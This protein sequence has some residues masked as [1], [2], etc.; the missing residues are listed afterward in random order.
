MTPIKKKLLRIMMVTVVA[1]LL[2]ACG[3]FSI[4]EVVSVRQSMLA[5]TS[6]LGEIIA[7]NST[8]ALTFNDP[9]AVSETL[10]S[11]RS[12]RHV[13]QAR[14][15][16]RDGSLFAEYGRD[17]VKPIEGPLHARGEYAQFTRHS[18]TVLRPIRFND[19]VIGSVYVEHDLSELK[20]RLLRYSLI[21]AGVLL[22]AL[23]AAFLLADRLQGAISGPILALAE[24]ARSIRNSGNY[25]MAQITG[26]YMEAGLLI[27]SFNDMINGIAERDAALLHH[28]E[29]LEEEVASRTAELR[30]VNSQLERAR[31]AAEAASRAKSE[32]L[33]N[34]SHEVRTPMNGILGMTELALDTDL[35]PL[36]REY[37]TLVRSSA[38]G[39]LNV[40]NDI[41]DFSKIEAGKLSLDSR[42]FAFYG[43]IAEVMKTLAVRAHQKGLELAFEVQEQIPADLAGDVGRLR[44]VIVNL[45]GNAI[46][47]TERGEVVLSVTQEQA[48]EKSVLLHFAIRDTGLGI[49]KDKLARIFEAFEQ[50]DTSTTR[51]HGG[52][53]L[54]LTISVRLVE[55]MQGKIWVES[56]PGRGSTFHFTARFETCNQQS[57]EQA[58]DVLQLRDKRALVVDDNATNRRIL[59]QML[60]NWGMQV[61]LAESGARV[62]K[63]LEDVGS[64]GNRYSLLL[65]D[66]HMPGMDGFMLLEAIRKAKVVNPA[67][68]I[69]LT[70]GDQPDDIRRSRELNIAEYAIK[71]ISQSELLALVLRAVAPHRASA[72]KKAGQTARKGSGQ[73]RPLRILLA[74]DNRLNQKVALGMLGRMRHVVTV[75]NNGREA[76]HAYQQREYDLVF[77]DIQMPEMDGFCAAEMIRVQQEKDGRKV[78]IIAM[79]AHAMAG[80]R[81]KCLAAGMDD[82]VSKPISYEE[83]RNA[84]LRTVPHP[85]ENHGEAQEGSAPVLNGSESKL[86][87][88]AQQPAQTPQSEF[89]DLEIVLDRC[90]GDQELLLDLAKMFPTEASNSLAALKQAHERGDL[91]GVRLHAH[92]LKGMCRA[93]ELR[94]TAE[95]AAALE[96]TARRQIQ[97]SQAQME[98][99]ESVLYQAIASVEQ[100]RTELEQLPSAVS[101]AQS[102]DAVVLEK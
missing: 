76:V 66:R 83:L 36:T 46:K 40:I 95:S 53:G 11:L 65:L 42:P 29:H 93:F 74:E 79:T 20:A 78:P 31:D 70:S 86:T 51:D 32:F 99:F 67:A 72:Q 26:G 35:S 96:D 45:V 59:E 3:A 10:A 52:T 82:Y 57:Q 6:L 89:I 5:E 2:L 63:M 68:I 62:L 71:P 77:M 47:F 50:A 39:L 33:A 44:Q 12:E 80:D 7:S 100:L 92:T 85:E 21:A 88:H 69:M 54:G 94:E 43:S 22:L 18:V 1:A 37:L 16:G 90:G 75:A 34:M 97:L 28:R 101:N 64:A 19:E 24:G 17:G 81:E 73:I 56:E 14:V 102:T 55:M 38:D 13:I 4:Y 58:E 15:Y 84:I 25:Q 27:E 91:A 61:D 41:L 48:D 49:A 60:S 30:T 23:L 9:K 8:A 98:Q 87:Q